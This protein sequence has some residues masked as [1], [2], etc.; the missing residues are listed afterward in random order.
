M[1]KKLQFSLIY[2]FRKLLFEEVEIQEWNRIHGNTSL[3]IP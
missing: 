3:Q 2:Y 1:T